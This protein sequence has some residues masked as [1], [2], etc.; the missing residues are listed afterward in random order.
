MVNSPTYLLQ[1]QWGQTLI[2]ALSGSPHL[3]CGP[4][5]LQM[6]RQLLLLLRLLRLGSP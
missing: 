6:D 4:P 3:C 5:R 2:V 1:P